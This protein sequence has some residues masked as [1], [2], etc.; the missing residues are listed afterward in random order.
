MLLSPGQI[1]ASIINDFVLRFEWAEDGMFED[2]SSNFAINRQ[3]TRQNKHTVKETDTHLEIITPTI[4]L[5]YDKKRLS[6]SGLK[7]ETTHQTNVWETT[8]R[9]G[10]T[11]AFN[12]GG[13]ARAL[14]GIDGR[15]DVSRAGFSFID[16]SDSMLF[17]E[18][19]V[20][21]RCQGDRTDGYFFSFGSNFKG[22][23]KAYFNISGHTPVISRFM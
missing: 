23:M 17:D 1:T 19:F 16:D 21:P 3:L 14:D 4:H 22:A 5:S 12:L 20:S 9:Y 11:S 2:R 7:I 6:P 15:C 18:G 8:W 10:E 13:T